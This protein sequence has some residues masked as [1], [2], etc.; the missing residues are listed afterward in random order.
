MALLSSD[1]I[2]EIRSVADAYSRQE[3]ERRAHA[4]ESLADRQPVARPVPAR[5][6]GER[7]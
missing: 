3:R 2:R 7:A 1:M 4:A 5:P 6:R